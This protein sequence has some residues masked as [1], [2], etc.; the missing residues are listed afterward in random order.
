MELR[1]SGKNQTFFLLV[2][3]FHWRRSSSGDDNANGFGSYQGAA[4]P[5]RSAANQAL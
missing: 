5:R 2:N 1:H 3:V 4:C